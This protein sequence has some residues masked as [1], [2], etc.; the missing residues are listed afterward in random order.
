MRRVIIFLG[1]ILLVFYLSSCSAISIKMDRSLEGVD[2]RVK[3][4]NNREKTVEI[5]SQEKNASTHWLYLNCNYIFGCYMRC[6]GPID[7]CRKVASIGQFDIKYVVSKEEGHS[8]QPNC[9]QFC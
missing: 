7:S 5:I 6:E 4:E 1:L 9:H 2:Y 3:G 8:S